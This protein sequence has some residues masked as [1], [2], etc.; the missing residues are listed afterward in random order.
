MKCPKCGSENVN[1]S[2]VN[3]VTLK[4]KGK[5]VLYYLFVWWWWVWIKWLVFT[6]PALIL[7]LFGHKKQKAV[8]KEKTVCVC[9]S[10]GYSWDLK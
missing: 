6:L 5:G 10:C 7:T 8:N 3:E 9:Q 1:T 4:N 2:V